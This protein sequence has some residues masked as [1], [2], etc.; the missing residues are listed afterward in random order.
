MSVFYVFVI[1]LCVRNLHAIKGL[2]AVQVWLE[3]IIPFFLH[4]LATIMYSENLKCSK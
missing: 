3:M 1:S 2:I 4:V